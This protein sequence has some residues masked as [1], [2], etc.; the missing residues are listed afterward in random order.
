MHKIDKELKKR[1]IIKRTII[2]NKLD[3]LK[4]GELV[5]EKNVITSD[6]T[7]GKY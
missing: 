7:F 5:Q 4:Q 6:E 1:R 2:K 3:L